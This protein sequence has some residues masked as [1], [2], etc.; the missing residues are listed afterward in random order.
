MCARQTEKYDEELGGTK[1]EA[2]GRPRQRLFAVC[3]RPK[4]ALAGAGLV[5]CS[6]S[7]RP[8]LRSVFH[9]LAVVIW[10]CALHP[11]SL[12]PRV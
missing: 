3:R 12:R 5:T 1:E 6:L 2:E 10:F 11:G 9:D 7:V 8:F 4:V